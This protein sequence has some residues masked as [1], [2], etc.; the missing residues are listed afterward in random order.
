MKRFAPW[1]GV[2]WIA[3]LTSEA[4]AHH[5]MEYIDMESYTTAREG[6]FVFHLHYDYMVDNAENPNEDH[7]EMT[8]GLSWGITDRLMFDAHTHFAR[9]GSDHVVEEKREQYEPWGPSPFMEAAAVDLQ[10][11]L[12]EGHGIDI[13]LVAEI[14]VPFERAKE[15]LGSEDNLYAGKL[16]AAKSFDG[17]RNVTLNIIYEVEGDED[18][19]FWAVGAKTPISGDEHGIAAGI[20]IQGNMEDPDENWSVLPGLYMPV[21]NPSIILKTGIQTGK[22]GGNDILRAGVTMIYRF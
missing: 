18:A 19:V 1:I 8:P 11:R 14:E 5:A 2:L 20:E 3:V 7:W 4:S 6:E 10:Y 15:V 13:A 16:I 21:G 17:H 22:E 12:T 9:F